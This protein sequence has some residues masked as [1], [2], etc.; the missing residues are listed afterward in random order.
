M[1]SI[2][3][4]VDT[5]GWAVDLRV[6]QV[7]SAL[8][9]YRWT[10]VFHREAAHAIS[11]STHDLLWLANHG[12]AHRFRSDI[13]ER[14]HPRVL[15][16]F[17]SWRYR[18]TVPDVV[19][20]GAIHAISA[21]SWPLVYHCQAEFGRSVH[22]TPE[23]IAECFVPSR[24]PVIGFVGSTDEYKGFPLIVEAVRRCGFELRVAPREGARPQLEMPAF[25]ESCNAIVVAS[26][27]E[28]F[29]T[30]AVESMAMNI[31]VLTTEVGVAASLDCLYIERTV[32]G[33]ARGLMQLFG[34]SKVLPQFSI[35]KTS[36]A[37]ERVF[38][39]MFS[40]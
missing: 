4:I 19:R 6:S 31:P 18:E 14:R 5:E 17:R 20:R 26:E 27:N 9:Q 23:G 39:E 36:L 29:G 10:K 32:D 11:T 34:R 24:V 13:A 33:I 2:L 12:A 30:I 37:H 3:A 1:K 38:E 22:Y 21:V 28:G 35:E 7:I 15:L 16:T 8:D 40:K 25:Y